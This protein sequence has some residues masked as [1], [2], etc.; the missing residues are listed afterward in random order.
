MTQSKKVLFTAAANLIGLALVL[1]AA[2]FGCRWQSEHGLK[3]AW[4]SF[5]TASTPFS[6]LRTGAWVVADPDLGYRLNPSVP[7]GQLP[8]YL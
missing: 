1:G 5:F 8:G 7:G 2:E 6:D 3:A 4:R